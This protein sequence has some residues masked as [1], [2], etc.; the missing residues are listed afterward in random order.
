MQTG[1]QLLTGFLLMLPFQ[2]RFQELSDA[3]E[4][5]YLG[6][7][8]RSVTATMSWSRQS[9]STVCCSAGMPYPRSLRTGQRLAIGGV[10]L[11][12]AWCCWSSALWSTC[13]P[14]SSR[15]QRRC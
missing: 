15:R 6:T 8:A 14:G 4:V 1:V 13:A 10:S 2:Q 5:I 9:A 12:S 3:Q 11:S 7:V